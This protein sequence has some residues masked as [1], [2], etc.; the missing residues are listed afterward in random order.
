MINEL[1]RFSKGTLLALGC[2]PGLSMSNALPVSK[3]LIRRRNVRR[4]LRRGMDRYL[5]GNIAP[6]FRGH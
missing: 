3:Y 4:E 6:R 5:H 2:V 1:Q